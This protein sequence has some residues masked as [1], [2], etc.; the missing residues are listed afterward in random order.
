MISVT[1]PMPGPQP[2]LLDHAGGFLWWYAEARNEAGDGIVLIWSYALPFLPGLASAARAGSPTPIGARPSVN[3]AVYRAGE[4]DGYWLEE[5]SPASADWD[6]AER[7]QFGDCTFEVRRT[8]ES[9]ALDATLDLRVAGGERL[10]GT[11]QWRGVAARAATTTA[12]TLAAEDRHAW[13]PLLGPSTAAVALQCGRSSWAFDGLG[14]FDR[15]HGT[16]MLDELGIG[17]WLWGHGVSASSQKIAYALIPDDG[18]DVMAFGVEVGADGTVALLDDLTAQFDGAH[19]TRYG[20]PAWHRWS[21]H[22][23]EACWL[24]LRQTQCVDLGPF[25]LRHLCETTDAA[26]QIAHGFSEVIRPDRIDL[27]RH[28][29][30]VQMRVGRPEGR[31]SMWLPLFHGPRTGRVGRLFRHWG[32]A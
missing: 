12:T 8:G 7:W 20:M 10:R 9:L 27:G 32:A 29:P 30:L 19:R 4:L 28:R 17:T 21:V 26:G 11:A 18:S 14:Y 25:Y 23:G 22:R 3:V 13:T 24:S 16:A 1:P 31:D 2:A 15:N 6:G 5:L